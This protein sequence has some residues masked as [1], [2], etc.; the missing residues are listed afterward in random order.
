MLALAEGRQ[1]QETIVRV[2]IHYSGIFHAYLYDIGSAVA[3][4]NDCKVVLRKGAKSNTYLQVIGFESDVRNVELLAASLQLQATTAMT[5]WYGQ[6][7][8]DGWSKMDS[9]KQ[10]RQFYVSFAQGLAAKLREAKRAGVDDAVANEATRTGVDSDTA[11]KSTDLV[12]V[13]KKQRVDEWMDKEYGSTLRTVRR[14]YASGSY[15]ASSAG[16]AAGRNAD[17]GNPRLGGRRELGR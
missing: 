4:A 3:R 8:T 11:R 10:R 2:E 15:G 9:F 1:E 13:S 7:N 6:Q 17:I 16:Y 14:N 5:R 12:L